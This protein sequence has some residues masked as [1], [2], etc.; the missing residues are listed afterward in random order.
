MLSCAVKVA[1]QAAQVSAEVGRALVTEIAILLQR[2][3]DDPF[4]FA[5]KVRIQPHR[6]NGSAFQNGVEDQR[7]S[8]ASEWQ[9]SG[10]HLV[11][12]RAKRKQ[13][14]ARPC[15]YDQLVSMFEDVLP[16][17]LKLVVALGTEIAVVGGLDSA[18]VRSCS[19]FPAPSSSNAG[20]QEMWIARIM[21]SWE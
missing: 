18:L 9:G 21:I 3:I 2:L 16:R 20:V 13:I 5:G 1:L 11:K 12:H 19:R 14:G 15:Q 17:S 10:T 6:S 7:P 8:I 4:Q